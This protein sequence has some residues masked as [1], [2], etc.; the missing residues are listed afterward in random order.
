MR[1]AEIFFLFN[2]LCVGN[3][4][5]CHWIGSYF[6]QVIAYHLYGAKPLYEP[7]LNILWIKWKSFLNFLQCV[8][9]HHIAWDDNSSKY[10]RLGC[11]ITLKYSCGVTFIPATPCQLSLRQ[12]QKGRAYTLV[13]SMS[14]I[15]YEILIGCLIIEGSTEWSI[16]F[17][18]WHF[19]MPVIV[20]TFVYIWSFPEVFFL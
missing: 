20:W 3:A 10:C 5:T 16:L 8:M 12:I 11:I 2:T 9:I 19:W 7:T 13:R 4:Y 17:C 14:E 6:I 18:G 1:G 15:W